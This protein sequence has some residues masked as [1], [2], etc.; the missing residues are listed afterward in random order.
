MPDEKV[1]P[2]DD[3]IP[4]LK[5]QRRKRTNR[6]LIM[7]L[8]IF[9]ILILLVVYFQ[10]PLSH[11]RDITVQGTEHLAPQ[12]IEEVSQVEEGTSLWKVDTAQVE[13]RIAGLREV[14]SA[15]VSRRFPADIQITV[16]EHRRIAYVDTGNQ[17]VPVLQNGDVLTDNT[18]KQLLAD[19]PLLINFTEETKLKA[20][21]EE[22]S[23]LG[24]GILNRISEVHYRPQNEEEL[25]LYMND[26]IEVVS[27]IPG[28]ATN[29]SS[30]P[31][32]AKEIDS[33][34]EGVLHMKMSSYF[35]YTGEEKEQQETDTAEE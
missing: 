14:E 31:A 23:R 19:A 12:K 34:A 6:R 1:V 22:L 17:Y 24:D 8:S 11:V 32:I 29:M 3:R 28:F 7:Y 13:K 33:D 27:A 30:Y 20:F 25:L 4:A 15:S 21:T 10:S 2:V 35:E 16:T 9:F 18:I 26:G 5:E